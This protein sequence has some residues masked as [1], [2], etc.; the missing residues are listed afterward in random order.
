MRIS[1]ATRGDKEQQSE[2]VDS[3]DTSNQTASSIHLS[4]SISVVLVIGATFASLRL[5]LSLSKAREQRVTLL[6]ENAKMQKQL[7]MNTLDKKQVQIVEQHVPKLLED[8]PSYFELNWRELVFQ[9]RL[10]TGSFGDCFKGLKGGR[11]VA[12]KRM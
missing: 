12:I 2:L 3:K 10:G 5:A 4:F 11:P 9:A 6:K 7:M 8:V 1:G